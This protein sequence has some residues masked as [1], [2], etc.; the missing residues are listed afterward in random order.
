MAA[1]KKTA[2]RRG[3][4]KKK[5]PKKAAD[6]ATL[7]IDA[8]LELAP[9]LGWRT[10]RMTDIAEETGLTLAGIHAVFPCKA[11]IL[12]GY[13]RRID[14]Q[15]LSGHVL[16][17]KSDDEAESPRDRLFELL[18]RRFDALNEHKPAVGAIFRDAWCDPATMVVGGPSL[19][20][21]MAWMLEAAGITP[22]G[23]R[24]GTRVKALALI[25]AN[26]FR[27]WLK[28]SSGDMAKTMAALDKGLRLA[29]RLESGARGGERAPETAAA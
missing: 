14:A 13:I 17:G 22:E 10:L 28:D 19:L 26:A 24:G 18:M 21:S 6:P 7:I 2:S 27:V 23:L 11:M 8:T 9:K 29:E 12:T 16:S 5:R 3:G 1:R 20:N 4:P 15:V 25:Y